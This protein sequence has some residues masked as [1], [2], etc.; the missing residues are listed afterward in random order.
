MRTNGILGGVFGFLWVCF[1]A[2]L[3]CVRLAVAEESGAEAGGGKKDAQAAQKSKTNEDTRKE[4]RKIF[5]KMEKEVPLLGWDYSKNVDG[6]LKSA[7]MQLRKYLN[8]SS[9]DRDE[10]MRKWL[11][12]HESE[13][14]KMG[15]KL[16]EAAK[17]TEMPEK[18]MTLAFQSMCDTYA[19]A[20]RSFWNRDFQ[21]A[22]LHMR[23]AMEKRK[24]VC[25][26]IG[27][28]RTTDPF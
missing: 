24:T 2:V 17:K 27:W 22:R 25:E 3:W 14:L 23:R 9:T 13:V 6:K 7:G 11:H 15:R 28:I 18:T 19:D 4:A 8:P 16:A 5:A 26:M 20:L 21:Q 12:Q 10:D 1:L